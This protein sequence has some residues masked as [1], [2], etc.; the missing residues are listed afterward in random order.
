MQQKI[1]KRKI[2]YVITKSNWGGAQR[3]VH[4][5]ATNLPKAKFETIVIL[6]GEGELKARL[7]ETQISVRTVPTLERNI[8]IFKDLRSFFTLLKIFKREE[9]DIIHLN[10]SKAGGLGAL[11]GRIYNLSAS[12]S[13]FFHAPRSTL[14]TTRIIF[15]AHGWAFNEERRM[16]S[17]AFIWFAS[18]ITVA[19]SHTT[20]VVSDYDRK[21]ADKMPLVKNKIIRIH[22]GVE[23][24]KF[25]A[26]GT[27][28]ENLLGEHAARFSRSI[29]VGTVA[30]LH[31][32][33]G[34]PYALQA[35]KILRKKES[36]K[37][38]V[39]VVIG[40]GEERG[41]LN[42]LIQKEGLLD[43]VFFVGRRENAPSFLRA[44]DIFLLPSIKEGLPYVVLEAGAAELPVVASAIGGIPE[45]ITDMRSGV[46]VKPKNAEE[47][48]LA[49]QFLISNKE[50]RG[51]FGTSLKENIG[52]DFST[53]RMTK[54]TMEVY[55]M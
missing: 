34:L 41:R 37:N 12:F 43:Q 14:H 22:N 28:R 16:L 25:A 29:W 48:A 46:L 21:Q 35:I 53:E 44:F 30:E 7:T 5:L 55:G 52:S 38:F 18:W 26:R 54:K 36:A 27:A 15:T 11:A 10:S 47:I 1:T 6:G 51:E 13:S 8:G 23:K 4:D 2:L 40:D 3:Y 17:Q 19:L 33:K 50:K 32:N 45:I 31:K 24:I 39:Y 9:P 20:I 49:L 42:E